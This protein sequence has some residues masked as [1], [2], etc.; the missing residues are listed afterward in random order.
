MLTMNS[1]VES[2][3]VRSNAVESSSRV[4]GAGAP[5][6]GQLMAPSAPISNNT[7]LFKFTTASRG[8]V[9]CRARTNSIGIYRMSIAKIGTASL[10]IQVQDECLQKGIDTG[11]K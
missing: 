10:Q 11:R 3:S 2:A 7:S 6:K 5:S 9:P 4:L 1:E 8:T